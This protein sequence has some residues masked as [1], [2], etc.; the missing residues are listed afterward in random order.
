MLSSGRFEQ[1]SNS[2]TT[3][4]PQRAGTFPEIYYFDIETRKLLHTF[5]AE[6]PTRSG[7]M[8][9]ALA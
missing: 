8:G 6:T 3:G 2:P 7:I 5:R 1:F 9:K 4:H